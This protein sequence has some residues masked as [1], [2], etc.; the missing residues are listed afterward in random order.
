MYNSASFCEEE[1]CWWGMCATGNSLEDYK[2][3][4]SVFYF[5]DKYVGSFNVFFETIFSVVSCCL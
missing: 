4:A 3:D 5:E 1:M 2:T